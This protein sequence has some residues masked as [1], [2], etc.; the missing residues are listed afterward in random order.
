[1]LDIL[2]AE[3]LSAFIIF[4]AAVLPITSATAAIGQQLTT[5][6][7]QQLQ[8][9]ARVVVDL[10]Q[11]H[12]YSGRAF[13][14]IGNKEMLD[15]F[16]DELDPEA[17]FLTAEDREFIHRRFDRTFKSVYLFRGDLQPAFEIF[18]L[19]AS[20][21]RTR[22]AWVERRLIRDFNLETDG[23]YGRPEKPAAAPAALGDET[24]ERRLLDQLL[25][26]MLAGRSLD[27]ARAFLQ[28][29][30]A[31]IG[32]HI[33]SY[34]SFS[35]RERFFDA[36]IRSFDPHSGYFSADTTREFELDMENAVVGLGLDLRKEEGRCL[37][38]RIHPGGPA[39]LHSDLA[40]GDTILAI[41]EEDSPWIDTTTRRMREIAALVRG[42]SGGKVRLAYQ[43]A[44]TTQRQEV[45]LERIRVILSADRA[46]GALSEVP[47]PTGRIRRIGWITL[48]NFYTG[49]EGEDKTSAARDVR[50]LIEQ[51]LPRRIDALV[52]DL[53]Y[54]PGG[55]LTEAAAICQLFLAHGPMM[56]SHGADGKVR[57]HTFPASAPHYAGPLV[58][59]V[60]GQSASAS[61][62]V[63][64]ALRHHRRALV[65]G[66]TQTFGKGTS[67]SY[68]PLAK[69]PG[70]D[71]ASARDW[72]T[73]RL[74]QER[75]YLPD[76]RGVQRAG[77]PSHIVLPAFDLP[78]AKREADL[79]GAL[80]VD[81][82]QPPPQAEF[83]PA[84]A[85][86]LT[87]ETIQHLRALAEQHFQG[88]PEWSLW[89]EEQQYA[90]STQKPAERPLR[91]SDRRSAWE[92]QL[93]RY[94][95]LQ[96][97]RRSMID[98]GAYPTEPLDLGAAK[99]AY[100]AHEVKLRASPQPRLNHL[101]RG[102]Y[103]IA[104]DRGHLREIRLEALPLTAYYGDG[105][106]LAAAFTAAAGLPLDA[107]Q[108]RRLLEQIS[109]LETKTDNSLLEAVGR[110]IGGTAESDQI[111]RGLEGLLGRLVALDR[112][113]HRERPGFDIPLREAQR[114]A[115]AWAAWTDQTTP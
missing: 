80:P 22:L 72:G 17:Y 90:L 102:A 93:A 96:A 34:D 36:L 21:A 108:A 46:R 103:C 5:S 62:I 23:H 30:Y 81:S 83:L 8:R 112:E 73:L 66:G 88:L 107:A 100:E 60:S 50:E 28:R 26:E 51:M 77:V 57:A 12:H 10:L 37:V 85:P 45:V 53:R 61:E 16:L 14:E 105:A 78:G 1:M 9:E 115:A 52:L 110:V 97:T 63:A 48:P 20:R 55:A 74:T 79:P 35:I 98:S 2:R 113:L 76:G 56:F 49:G 91:L 54:N 19:F 43:A 111:R 33:D 15:R 89:R 99:A 24:W 39:D 31:A 86:V 70:I 94:Q 6:E 32:R 67:Q 104:T 84:I 69:I 114:L 11:N 38:S 95:S 101:H 82:I 27:E 59:L 75:F 106:E 3:R 47:D 7:Q 40:P 71:P 42:K 25:A 13:R 109:T 41:A 68:I 58:V 29:R 64:G 18:D 4:V 65:V 87:D 44:G 92:A